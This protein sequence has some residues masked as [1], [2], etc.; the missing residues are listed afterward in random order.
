LGIHVCE[1]SAPVTGDLSADYDLHVAEITNET[2]NSIEA[3]LAGVERA[4]ERLRAGNYRRCQVCDGAID[5]A[6]L[7][8]NPTLTTCAAHPELG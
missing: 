1:D 2:V 7:A 3:T 5:D 8:A 6:A 4:L